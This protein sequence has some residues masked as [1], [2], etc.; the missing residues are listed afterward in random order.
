MEQL[1]FIDFILDSQENE[2]LTHGFLKAKSKEELGD[3]FASV[4]QYGIAPDELDKIWKIREKLP[5]WGPRPS[6]FY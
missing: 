4:P 6:P 3:F 1:N 5:K 2:K